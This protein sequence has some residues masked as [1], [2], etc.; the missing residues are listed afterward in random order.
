MEKMISYC[1]LRCDQCGAYLATQA[2]DDE[3]RREVAETWSRMYQ[4]DI[5]P[6][7]IHCDGCVQEGG[8]HFGHCRVCEIRNCAKGRGVIHC[9]HCGEYTCETLER[10]FTLAPH[11][12]KQLDRIRSGLP[13][14]A[15]P[16]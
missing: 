7:H 16:P 8:R 1:G 11:A 5:R 2:D 9:G 6:E 13:G 10:F 12:R 15:E 4:A 14:L 3:K